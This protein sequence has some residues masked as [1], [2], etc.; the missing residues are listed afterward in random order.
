MFS[1]ARLGS[2]EK[3][4]WL[5]G[6]SACHLRCT[7]KGSTHA[8]VCVCVCVHLS[9]CRSCR[10]KMLAGWPLHQAH[11]IPSPSSS[12]SPTDTAV[13]AAVPVPAGPTPHRAHREPLEPPFLLLLALPP[14][15]PPLPLKQ[16]FLGAAFS[17][18]SQKSP[19]AHPSPRLDQG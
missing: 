16:V 10:R 9:V 5:A 1:Y 15:A 19:H 6:A 8:C 18:P 11:T 3:H 4:I 17:G 12:S 13:T 14:A 7:G 2:Y